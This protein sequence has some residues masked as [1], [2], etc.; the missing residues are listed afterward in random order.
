MDELSVWF[1]VVRAILPQRY[2]A[3]LV[4]E[5]RALIVTSPRE[6]RVAWIGEDELAGLSPTKAVRLI[7]TKL[8]APESLLMAV[9][10]FQGAV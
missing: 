2:S 8:R 1:E 5:R 6:D 3:R 9:F 7:E 10:D 4:W